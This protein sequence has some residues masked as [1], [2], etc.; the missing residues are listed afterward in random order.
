[1][2]RCCNILRV[3]LNA[4]GSSIHPIAPVGDTLEADIRQAPLERGEL[5]AAGVDGVEG[6][7]DHIG[8]REDA[9]GVLCHQQNVRQDQPDDGQQKLRQLPVAGGGIRKGGSGLGD[10]GGDIHHLGLIF[11]NIVEI[12]RQ[13]GGGLTGQTHDEAAAGLVAHLLHHIQAVHP[14]LPGHFG[15]VQTFVEP[16]VGALVAHEIPVGAGVKEPLVALPA[17]LAQRQSHGAA[18]EVIL[19]LP[20]QALQEVIVV[21]AVLAAPEQEGAVSQPVAL[22]EAVEDLPRAQ[23]V[24]VAVFIRPALD[25]VEAV[26]FADAAQ[27]HRAP[28]QHPVSV[29]SPAGLIRQPPQLPGGFRRPLPD[30]ALIFRCGQPAIPAELADQFRHGDL[31]FVSC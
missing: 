5:L 20:D 8:T 25:A 26:V 29:N 11:L 23:P 14:V 2:F 18:G 30:Q 13:M 31:S 28:N 4:D 9:V 16:P 24:A 19:Q 7:A 21:E 12:L 27:L 15:G 3:L 17:P 22:L 6:L 1:M 10:K